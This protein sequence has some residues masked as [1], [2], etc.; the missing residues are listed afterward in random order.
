MPKLTKVELVV[1]EPPSANRIWRNGRGR[2]YTSSAA[3]DFKAEVLA[4]AYKAG[5]TRPVFGPDAQLRLT[6]HWY[7]QRKAGDTSNR[8][9]VVEDALNG[10]VWPDDRQV[11]ELHVFRIDGQRPGRLH[12]LIEAL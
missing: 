10:V 5:I 3:K 1:G 8:I 12:I 2:T 4:A 7:R 6:L 9:K 11:S